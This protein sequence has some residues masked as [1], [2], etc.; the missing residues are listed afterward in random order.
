MALSRQERLQLAAIDPELVEF[1]KTTTPP[2]MDTSDPAKLIAGLRALNKSRYQPPSPDSGVVELDIFYPARDGHKLRAHIY[3]PTDKSVTPR[4]LVVYFHGGGWTI[5]S[6]EDTAASCRNLVQKLGVVCIAPSYRQGPEDPFPAGINDA[7]DGVQWIAA[8]AESELN[9][10][11]SD[12]FIV[13]GSSPGANMTAVISHLARDEGLQ[14]PITGL[15]LLA[16][17]ILLEEAKEALPEKYREMYLSRTQKECV[18]APVLSP[19]LEKLFL[20]SVRGDPKSPLFVPYIWPTSH[21]DL[22]RTYFQVCGMDLLRDECMIYEQVLREDNGAETKLDIYPG[23][24]HIFWG[25]FPHLTQGKKA[26]ADLEAGI[27][28]LLRK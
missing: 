27:K 25:L 5:G 14:P 22:P 11:L 12:G 9:V 24:P 15:F 26:A 8:H 20:N 21:K 16:P 4:P 18:N 10:S 6:P 2:K 7:W 13:G 1:L 19:A 3:E 28:W 17:P 23:M